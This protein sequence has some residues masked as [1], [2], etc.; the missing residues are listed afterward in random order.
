MLLGERPQGE[1]AVGWDWV[2]DEERPQASQLLAEEQRV[3]RGHVAVKLDP[4]VDLPAHRL[5]NRGEALGKVGDPG[6]LAQLVVILLKEQDLS[7]P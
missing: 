4:Q 7:A 5:A 6:R 1:D 2:L 3:T